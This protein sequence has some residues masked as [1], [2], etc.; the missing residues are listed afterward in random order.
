LFGSDEVKISLEGK[1]A[2]VTGAASGVGLAVIQQYLDSGIHGLVAV[3]LSPSL[4]ASLIAMHE[5]YAERLIYVGGDVCLESTAKE[6]TEAAISHFG[7]L[8]VMVNNAGASVVKPLHEHT[9]EEWDRIMDTNVKAMFWSARQVVPI[10]MKQ[11]GGLILNTGSISGHVGLKNQ[12]AYG[13]SKGAVHQ[14]TRQMAIEY[15]KYGI[16]VNA[17]ALG[18]VNTPIVEWSAKQTSNPEAFV[19]GLMDAHPIGRIA[20]AQEVAGFFTYLASDHAS[21]FT[22]AI[23]SMDGGFIAQ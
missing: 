9:E 12:G 23:L 20:S 22:G 16:R 3:D 6:F 19:R 21:F 11:Q 4:P 5:K 1:V 18:T 17:I 13:P 14:L 10:M 15:A 7:R 8:D 2:V